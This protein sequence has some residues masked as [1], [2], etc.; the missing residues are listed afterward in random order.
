[1]TDHPRDACGV[2]GIYGVDGAASLI[3]LSLH[4]LQHRGQESAGVVTSCDGVFHCH[5]GMGLVSAVFARGEA[6]NL[7]GAI[8]IGHVR[9]STAGGSN[10]VNAQPLVGRYIH[11]QAALAHNGTLIAAKRLTYTLGATGAFFQTDADSEI[12]LHQLAQEQASTEDEIGQVLTRVGPAF[13]L[14]L[15]FA[16]RLI[17]ARDPYGFRPLVLGKLR[18][19]YVA[20]SESCAF[21][22]IGAAFLREIEPGEMVICSSGACRSFF[23][24]PPGHPHARC[25]LELIYFARP[26]SLVFGEMPHLFRQRSGRALAAEHPAEADI[27][28][29]IPDSG[30]SAAMGYAEAAGLPLERGLIRNHYV[31][32]SFIAPGQEAR[33]AAVRMKHNVV[34]E[35]VRGKRVVLVDDSLI[36]GTTTDALGREL[37]NAG[38]REVHLRIACPPT[39][40]PCVYGVNF[41]RREELLAHNRSLEEIRSHLHMDSLGYLSLEG[42]TGLFSESSSFCTACWSGRYPILDE[43][44]PL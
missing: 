41:P 30:M 6:E 26:D 21:D 3:A 29:A 44:I 33:A 32:R 23:F 20:A 24:C 37:R 12:F 36:R 16:D 7:P 34:R 25:L 1:M 2:V 27:V 31:G 5:K 9:Y 40:H 15:L 38:A 35:V 43:E 42:I 10:L 28:V 11:G 8:G 39:R 14:V 19:G 18:D 13:S 22:Q 4:A 17:A